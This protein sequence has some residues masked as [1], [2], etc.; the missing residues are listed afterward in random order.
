MNSNNTEFESLPPKHINPKQ[1]IQAMLESGW[2]GVACY[3]NDVDKRPSKYNKKDL[4]V[5]VKDDSFE[6]IYSGNYCNWKYAN[7]FDPETG[8]VIIDFVD[9]KVVLED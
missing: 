4:I 2:V 9:G 8:K 3:V 7:P 6:H 5:S 1:I